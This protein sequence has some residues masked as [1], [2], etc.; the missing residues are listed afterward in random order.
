MSINE[1]I[2]VLLVYGYLMV[3]ISI[4]AVTIPEIND[5]G[6]RVAKGSALTI[7]WFFWLLAK[8]GSKFSRKTYNFAKGFLLSILAG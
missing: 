5:V 4:A 3:G 7:G 2:V 6:E 8:W 1:T